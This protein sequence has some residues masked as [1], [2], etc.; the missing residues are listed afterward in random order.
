MPRKPR[1]PC[2]FRGCPELCEEP[3]CAKHKRMVNSY[4]NRYERSPETNK[5][6]NSRWRKIR[7]LYVKNHPLCEICLDCGVLKPAEE[8]H[9]I[10]PLS[11][12]GTHFQNNL[13]SLCKSCHSRITAL[14][15]RNAK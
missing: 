2:R 3:Y 5:R 4:Y 1:S 7:A 13:M 10:I 6:Y 14:A 8:V 9:H 12:G 15:I 11:Q